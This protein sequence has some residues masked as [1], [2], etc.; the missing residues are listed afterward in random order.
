MQD[1]YINSIDYY[2]GLGFREGKSPPFR[3]LGPFGSTRDYGA[4]DAS[5][6]NSTSVPFRHEVE[7]ECRD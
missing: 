2:E 3:C 4:F 6:L 7:Q 1:L 5:G